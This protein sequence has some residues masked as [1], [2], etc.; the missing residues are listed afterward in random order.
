MPEQRQVYLCVGL[1]YPSEDDDVKL[2]RRG[3]ILLGEFEDAAWRSNKRGGVARVN[4]VRAKYLAHRR[5]CPECTPPRGEG[6]D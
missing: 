6:D 1:A 2:C 3:R 5:A 4:G